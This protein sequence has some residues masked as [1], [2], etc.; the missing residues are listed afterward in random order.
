MF[1][2]KVN[3]TIYDLPEDK[4][5]DFKATYPDAVEVTEEIQTDPTEGKTNGAVETDAAV[6]P[7]TTPSRASMIVDAQPENTESDSIAGLLES[8]DLAIKNNKNKTLQKFDAKTVQAEAPISEEVIVEEP[9]PVVKDIT[10]EKVVQDGILKTSSKFA[11]EQRKLINSY[12]DKAKQVIQNG[13]IYNLGVEGKTIEDLVGVETAVADEIKKRS[14]VYDTELEPIADT[15]IGDQEEV[16]TRIIQEEIEKERVKESKVIN[17]SKYKKVDQAIDQGVYD[18]RRDEGV[19]QTLSEIPPLR[20]QYGLLNNQRRKL[21]STIFTSQDEAAISRAK[22][23]LVELQPKLDDAFMRMQIGATG[24]LLKPGDQGYDRQQKRI[25]AASYRYLFDEDSGNRV[26]LT[27]AATASN[28]TDYTE[29]VEKLEQRYYSLDEQALEREFVLNV[30]N[31]QDNEK[32][33]ATTYDLKPTGQSAAEMSAIL[34]SRGYKTDANGIIKNVPISELRFM[35]KDFV[36]ESLKAAQPEG[37]DYLIPDLPAMIESLYD[38]KIQL[39]LRKEALNTTYVLN[40]DPASINKT[41]L[42]KLGRYIETAAEASGLSEGV[43]PTSVRKQLDEQE[44]LFSDAGI[45]LTPEQKK[46][47]ERTFGTKL[48]EG[49]GEFTPELFKFFIANKIAG[50]A[51]ITRYIAGLAKDGRKVEAFLASVALEEIKFQGVSFGEAPTGAGGGFAIGGMAASKFI[52][53]FSGELA[54]FNNLIEKSIGGAVGGVAGSNTAVLAE[55]II[56]DLTGSDSVKKY[57]NDYYGA[58]DDPLQEELVSAAVFG[59]LGITKLKGTDFKSISSRRKMLDKLNS[60]IRSDKAKIEKG[61]PRVSSFELENKERLAQDLKRTIDQADK[62]FNDMDLGKQSEQADKALEVINDTSSTLEQKRQAQTVVAN[63]EANKTAMLTKISKIEQNL[64]QSEVFK[65]KDKDGPAIKVLKDGETFADPNTKAEYDD[66][67]GDIKVNAKKLNLGVVSEELYH[68]VFDKMFDQNPKA[69]KVFKEKIQTDVNNAFKDTKFTVGD[70]KNLTFEEAIKEAYKETPSSRPEEYVAN[71]VNFLQQPQYRDLLLE[72]GLLPSIKR[73]IVNIGNKMG[74]GFNGKTN[75]TTAAELINF[76]EGIG[77][78]LT[79]G[80]SRGVRKKIEQFEKIQIDGQKLI[81]MKTGEKPVS[82]KRRAK[83]I[84]ETNKELASRNLKVEEK[85]IQEGAFKVS[86]LEGEA[87]EK[88]VRELEEINRPLVKKLAFQ[89]ANNPK[90]LA[91]EKGKRKTVQ[92]FEQGYNEELTKI[93]NNY[94]PIVVTGKPEDLGKRINFGAYLAPRL[95]LRYGNILKQLKKGE[96]ETTRIEGSAAEKMVVEPGV[97]ESTTV[98]EKGLPKKPSEATEYISEQLNRVVDKIKKSGKV[99]ALENLTKKE[100]ENLTGEEVFLKAESE[101]IKEAFK[102]KEISSIKQATPPKKV[103]ELYADMLGMNNK[104]GLEILADPKR[105]WNKENSAG[106]TAAK[107]FISKNINYFWSTLP[108]TKTQPAEGTPKATGIYQ[109]TIGKA[110]YNKEGKLVGTFKQ[111]KDIFDGKNTIVNGVE[112]NKI[113]PKTGKKMPLYRDAQHFKAGINFITRNRIMEEMVP[114]TAKRLSSGTR[115]AKEIKEATPP[116]KGVMKNKQDI[117]KNKGFEL[118]SVGKTGL[119]KIKSFAKGDALDVFGSELTNEILTVAKVLSTAG[120]RAYSY[121]KDGS[122][123]KGGGAI[124]G[125]YLFVTEPG[126]AALKY[127]ENSKEYK[128]TADL[129]AAGELGSL[130]QLRKEIKTANKKGIFSSEDITAIK[131]AL[132]H[133]RFSAEQNTKDKALIDKGIDLLFEG[134]RKIYEKNPNLLPEIAFVTYSYNSNQNPFRDAATLT[135]G[136]TGLKEGQRTWEE[137][138]QQYGPFMNEFLKA[139]TGSR[140]AFNSFKDMAKKQYFQLKLSKDASNKL[141][142]TYTKTKKGEPAEQWRGKFDFHPLQVES[143]KRAE[144]SGDYSNVIDPMIRAYNEY[145]TLDPFTIVREGITDAARYNVQVPKKY[146]KNLNVI[147]K[148]GDLIYDV[149]RTEAGFLE[150][151]KAV[152]RNQA[153]KLINEYV[154]LSE[155]K[156]KAET[157]NNGEL[158]PSLSF[159]EK[160]SNEKVIEELSTLDKALKVARDPKA[161][162]KKIRVFD[163]DDTL[164]RS[165]SKVVYEMP[166]G[167]TGKLNATQFAERAGELEAQGATFDF[168]E[169]SKVVDGKKGPVFKAIENIVAKRGAEDVFIL[170]ARPADAAGPIKEFMDA[171]GVKIPIENIVGL[172][173]GK[174]QAKGRWIT[175]KAAEG[176]NDFF[177]VDDAYKN[178]K[179]VKQALDVFDVKSKVQQAKVRY[180]KDINLSKDFNDIIENKTGIGAD[181]VYSR[182]KAQVVGASKG[183]IF[184]GIPYSAQDFTGLLYETLGKGKLGDQQMAWYKYNLLDPF[185]RGVNDISRDR[186]AMMNDYKSLK[187]E[188]GVIPKDL[189]KKLPGEPYTKEQAVRVYTWNTLQGMEVP[190]V[191]KADLKTLNEFVNNNPELKVFAEQLVAINKGDGYAKPKETWLTGSITTDLLEGLNTTKRAKYLEQWQTNVDEIFS[192]ANL[193]KLEAAYGKKYRKAIENSLQRMKTGRNRSFSDDSLTG[194]FTDWLNGSIGVTMFFNT[195]SALLQTLSSVNFVNFSDNNPLK[196]AKAFG[197]QKQYWK[198]FKY[199]MN[200]D[201]LKE[202]RGGLRMNVNEA[203]IAEAANKN[204]PRGVVNRLLQFGFTPTQIADSFAIASGG[205]TFYRNRVKTYEKQGLSTAEAEAKAFEDFRETSEES[206]QSSRPDRISMQ[207]AGPLGRPILAYGNTPAQYVRLTDKAIK[208]LKAGRGDAKTNISKIIYYTTVQNLIFNSL[209]QGLFAIAFGEADA[210]DEKYTNKYIDVANGMADSIL[211]GTGVGGAAVSVGKNAIIRIMREQEK[212]MPKLEKVGYELTKISPPVSSKLSKIN[213]AARSYQWDKDEM[214][215]KGFS[216][217]NPA[218]LAGANVIS[219]TTNVPLDRA[220]RKVNN[221]IAATE[222]DAEL[223]ERLALMGGWPEWSIEEPEDKK[224]KKPQLRKVKKKKVKKKKKKIKR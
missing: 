152:T 169:F 127:G 120:N 45:T 173:D 62:P 192:E 159:T 174:A 12:R 30:L 181:K 63:Y 145:V 49:L 51:G 149:I 183:S 122:K 95:K 168:A 40:I 223:W 119:D 60:E 207:Q 28:V 1:T 148:A 172:G 89:A 91:L 58:M 9:V 200:S 156:T 104:V 147:N 138:V 33:L 64:K 221:V 29:E 128:D 98:L 139:V 112:F 102:D 71:V 38:E 72:Q 187:K 205:A 99:K 109:T 195:R 44:K 208:D 93:I 17:A 118:I 67:S 107:Q 220:I 101:A 56:S 198:D 199:L 65:N 48:V 165:N 190:G 5:A 141:D 11:I 219:A 24:D 79:R 27:E 10:T 144:K 185:A 54:R 46:N 73:S 209:Q 130:N 123:K 178:V 108:K 116:V 59:V 69:A 133:K 135:G 3:D 125:G 19:K 57:L 217:D 96:V 35:N 26:G 211:R 81:D 22:R 20:R 13:G 158:P 88:V 8:V 150:G 2:F 154:K 121:K 87:R 55:A 206:Q 191:S 31:R 15:F 155:G 43:L 212:K 83:E 204:G 85:I 36:Q 75:F 74:I 171:L 52:G 50:A 213:Q 137:H 25:K 14:R 18:I 47:F 124:G 186:V 202:R 117:V 167:K 66:I 160:Q 143:Y 161:P 194:K 7:V 224:K 215:S 23:Q 80:T 170:T 126:R 216:I 111:F 201:F 100:L 16:F 6:A 94:E 210:D 177:F 4:V 218:Y 34:T 32:N 182:A 193:N 84:S 131:R 214:I 166:D 61:D 175:S 42:G 82:E 197:N 188:L 134:Y 146:Q 37:K 113:D 103:I 97:V 114:D 110:F 129:V 86:E 41:A 162:V 179:A 196:A 70:K 157:K 21:E 151:S 180:A 90:I 189:R 164:A 68:A 92:E 163:F 77:T 76:L 78:T 176:Y 222:A 153:Q 39:D 136:Q 142:T 105:N 53:K 106:A 184:K 115:F 140:E 132:T 203:D